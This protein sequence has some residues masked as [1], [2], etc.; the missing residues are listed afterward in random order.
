M[1]S[2]K[3]LVPLLLFLFVV[4]V[5]G[6]T[7]GPTG[8]A[9]AKVSGTVNLDGKPMQDGEVRFEVAGQPSKIIP[10]KDG[11]FS[12]DVYSGKNRVDVVWEKDGGPNPM[13]P[14]LPP[15]KVNVVDPKFSGMNSPFS[16]E[17]PSSGKTDMNFDVPS[18]RK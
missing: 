17:V 6:C 16:V 11:A 18:A 10:V 14:K 7:K 13:D 1:V 9:L 5:V 4:G 15:I 12:G 8:P 3:R 2:M